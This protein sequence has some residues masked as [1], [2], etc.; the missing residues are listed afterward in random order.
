MVRLDQELHASR[1]ELTHIKDIVDEV[2]QELT[3]RL[4]ID[5]VLNNFIADV[6]TEDHLVKSDDGVDRRSDLMAH[7]GEETVLRLVEH[8]DLLTLFLRGY[9]L[10]VKSEP[11]VGHDHA[12]D[13]LED[14]EDQEV[15]HLVRF[16]GT[17]CYRIVE[18]GDYSDV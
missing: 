16:D 11:R 13:Y 8:V 5:G 6:F 18:E 14:R 9:E 7:V 12:H 1:L 4:D 3:C 10:F 15:G 2:E 17:E